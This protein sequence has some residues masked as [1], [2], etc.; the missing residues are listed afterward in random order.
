MRQ[1][2]WLVVHCSATMAKMDIGV[3]E[4]DRWHK[5]RGWAG[6]GYHY[7]IR[8]NGKIEKGRTEDKVGAHVKGYNSDSIGVCVVGGIDEQGHSEANYTPAQYHSLRQLLTD[9]KS[10]YPVAKLRGHRDFPN[11]HKSCPC[12]D[13]RAWWDD[14]INHSD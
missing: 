1:I 12:F 2:E 3:H 5:D 13:V 14:E 7:V 8:R 11:V 4:I 10:R 6:I 9:L